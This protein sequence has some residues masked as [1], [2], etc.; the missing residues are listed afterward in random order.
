M[1]VTYGFFNSVNGD[2]KYNADQMS[3][4][5]RGIVSQGVFQHLDSGMAVSAGTGL[6]VSVA[7]GRAIIQNRWVQNSAALNLT[8]S[9]ASET[10]GRKDAVVIRLNKSSRAISI[11]VK[12]GTPAASPV[13]PSMTRDET[14][15]EMALAYVNVAAGASSVTVTDKRSDSS[16]CGWAS[17]AQATS[18]EVDQMLNDMKTGFDGVPYDSPGAAVRGSDSSIQKEFGNSKVAIMA[19]FVQGYTYEITSAG[20]TASLTPVSTSSAMCCAVI[21]Y[22][23]NYDVYISAVG[24]PGNARTYGFLDADL[25]VIDRSGASVTVDNQKLTVPAN[26]KYI[27]VNSYYNQN[28]KPFA[29]L[30]M[31]YDKIISIE[32]NGCEIIP[33]YGNG[34]WNARGVTTGAANRIRT[35]YIKISV[36]DIIEIKN[37]SLQHA[38]A[39][40]S[41]SVVSSSTIVRNDSSWNTSDEKFTSA[42]NGFLV[43]AFRKSTDANITPSDYDGSIKNYKWLNGKNY[44]SISEIRQ[45]VDELTNYK[46]SIKVV[47]GNW[48]S[49]GRSSSYQT[50]FIC[51]DR[52]LYITKGS[53]ITIPS[54]M[55]LFLHKFSADNDRC[56]VSD[57]NTTASNYTFTDTAWYGITLRYNDYGNI[58][59]SDMP[60]SNFNLYFDADHI[61]VK[62]MTVNFIGGSSAEYGLGGDNTLFTLPNERK[63]AID[64]GG[65]IAYPVLK[66]YYYKYGGLKLDYIVISH[67][68]EDHIGGLVKAL[69]DGIIDINGATMFL[70]DQSAFEYARE[71]DLIGEGSLTAYD[72]LQAH[73]ENLTV[74]KIYPSTELETH[75]IGENVRLEFFNADQSY[76]NGETDDY[77]NYSLG[78]YV[79]M[80]NTKICMT[81]DM[82]LLAEQHTQPNMY[83]ATILKAMHHGYDGQEAWLDP[84][85][86]SSVYPHI[87]ISEDGRN[88]DD[89]IMTP[90]AAQQSWCERYNVPNYRTSL[91][92][93]ISV[94]VTDEGYRIDQPVTAFIRNGKN[95]TFD[96]NQPDE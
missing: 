89:L 65:A 7:A 79:I 51:I 80:G 81:G 37:G 14:T 59:P 53:T 42:Y 31:T 25:T 67:Y 69:D 44:I 3:E 40:W 8:I 66:A 30:Y 41:G 83:R 94:T 93:V 74:T 13:A 9:D 33:I 46:H 77:N 24:G 57:Y 50:Y 86:M 11:A 29:A 20:S 96:D 19:D 63:M 71:H 26:T 70:P 5:F 88:H 76:L 56:F 43:V 39:I 38:C 68:H 55:R 82:S 12:T 48:S 84:Y 92:G 72:A 75:Y 23:D 62:N 45:T 47:R 17:V 1:A 15:Y 16:V 10:Y 22:D 73:L 49:T 58:S 78:C 64:F 28:V 35:N 21:E 95:W 60:V 4:Y 61:P 90:G 85:F 6:S 27:L 2:R 36:G 52:R 18:G 87:L 91:L 34:S 54:G 32:K